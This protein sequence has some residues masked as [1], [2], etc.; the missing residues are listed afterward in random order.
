MDNVKIEIK[1]NDK[2]IVVF[3]NGV[4]TVDINN[5]QQDITPLHRL[6]EYLSEISKS[7]TLLQ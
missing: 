6:V 7:S 1:I 4:L 5:I 3:D 2:H